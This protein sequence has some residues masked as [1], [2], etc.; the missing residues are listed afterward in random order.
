MA[1]LVAIDASYSGR[2]GDATIEQLRRTVELIEEQRA[3]YAKVG[4][5][6]TEA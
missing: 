3:V 5:L 1:R 6:D 2:F 4:L